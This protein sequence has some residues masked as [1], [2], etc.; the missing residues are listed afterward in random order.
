MSI[1]SGTALQITRLLSDA[2]SPVNTADDHDVWGIYRSPDLL[3]ALPEI[4]GHPFRGYDI[5]V[6]IGG[7]ARGLLLGPLVAGYL[8]TGFVPAR[9]EHRYQPGDLYVCRSQPDWEGKRV[10]FSLQRHA[11]VKGQR[12]LMVDDWYTTG[13]QG[14][15]IAELVSLA[16]SR[17]VG[18][19]VIVEECLPEAT[20]GLGE[21]SALLH[22][23]EVQREFSESAFKVEDSPKR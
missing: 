12:V 15:A 17:L 5:D 14:R 13:N 1:A 3:R 4:L 22:W 6:V 23:S 21:F 8:G 16:G 2:L 19:S 7:E 18:T 11:L 10:S 20:L 9:K